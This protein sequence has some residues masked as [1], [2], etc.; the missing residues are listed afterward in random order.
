MPYFLYDIVTPTIIISFIS[1]LY[2]GCYTKQAN[3]YIKNQLFTYLSSTYS[4]ALTLYLYYVLENKYHI[5]SKYLNGIMLALFLTAGGLLTNQIYDLIKERKGNT[6]KADDPEYLFIVSVS[7]LSVTFRMVM[8]GEIGF[9]IPVALLLG[10]YFWLDTKTLADIRKTI[11]VKHNRVLE[12][13]ILYLLGIAIS[14]FIPLFFHKRTP[15]E[16]ITALMY[17]ILVNFPYKC[18]R[19]K[20]FK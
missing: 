20:L 2:V 8:R 7:V 11:R 17:G 10:R 6:F 15:A 3:L 18:I 13:G 16:L 19:E 1:T 5:D 4:C 12:T 14:T 9:T